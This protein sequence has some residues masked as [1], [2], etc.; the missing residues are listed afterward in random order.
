MEQNQSASWFSQ[1]DQPHYHNAESKPLYG[2]EDP[3]PR[4]QG[5]RG[6]SKW[7]VAVL[8]SLLT[9]I[10]LGGALGGGLGAT[11]ANCQNEKR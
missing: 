11:L 6:P 1:P 7:T 4:R 8:A 3:H 10:V 2:N 9:A 5:S